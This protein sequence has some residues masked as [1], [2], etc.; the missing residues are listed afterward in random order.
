MTFAYFCV[1]LSLCSLPAV[2]SAFPRFRHTFPNWL[3]DPSIIAF[4][5][6]IAQTF[7]QLVLLGIIMVGQRVDSAAAERRTMEVLAGIADELDIST[8]GGLHDVEQRIL[9]EIASIRGD[10]PESAPGD[11]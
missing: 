5:A 7:L 11:S 10:I 6:W 4:V 8:G 3:T 9:N 1:A 2:L